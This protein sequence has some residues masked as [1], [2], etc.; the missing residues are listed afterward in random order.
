[1]DPAMTKIK[2][3]KGLSGCV[4]ELFE[5]NFG[6]Y[7]VKKTSADTSYN[8]R[9]K[10]QLSKQRLFENN[11]IKAPQVYDEGYDEQGKFFFLMEYISGVTFAE[12]I[13]I[14]PFSQS[15][16]FFKMILEGA[17]GNNSKTFL[18]SVTEIRLK[19]NDLKGK[20]SGYIEWFEY[21]E[22][23]VPDSIP[24]SLTHGDLTFENIII[25]SK[26]E[27]YYIDFLDSFIDSP[28]IDLGKLNQEL[29]MNWSIRNSDPDNFLLIKYNKLFKYFSEFCSANK[30][31]RHLDF[32]SILTLLRILPYSN[33]PS[34]LKLINNCLNTWKI[35]LL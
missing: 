24:H 34:E 17:L 32:F 23:N 21:L 18:K 20:I 16:H 5:D 10:A 13:N 22:N 1:V 14:Y 12:Y 8:N 15:V 28:Y 19:I 6:R 27:I 25:S 26:G 3:L 7:F 11:Y 35:K 30:F 31:I 4:V 29:S 9:L 33:T 2:D